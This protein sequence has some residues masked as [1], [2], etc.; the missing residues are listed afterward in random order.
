M[1]ISVI[2][3]FWNSEKWLSRCLDS[4]CRQKGDFEFILVDD[5]STD[6]GFEI[7]SG[8]WENDFR[9]ILL[10]NRRTAGVSGARN[11]GIDHADGDWITFLDADDEML[12]DAYATFRKVISEDERANIHQL[13]HLRH[14][15]NT[16]R[17][18][19][20]YQNVSGVYQFGNLPQMWFGVWNKL[21]NRDFLTIRFDER[22]QYGE[23]G[24]FAL[25]CLIKDNYIHHGDE[26]QL[27][28]KHRFDNKQSLS[29]IKTSA[30]I[31]KQLFVY[32]EL[33]MKQTD[34]IVKLDLAREIANLWGIRLVKELEAEKN[35]MMEQLI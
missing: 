5:N 14:Y 3:P 27:A 11:T 33:Y 28:V 19:L 13:N 16:N 25:E 9:F 17:T 8:Y 23:D 21:F 32:D 31:H 24:L 34:V 12:P 35:R 7:A 18:V 10:K 1:K 29:H 22:L 30:D 20:K 26:K 15:T 4:L 2:V 6:N